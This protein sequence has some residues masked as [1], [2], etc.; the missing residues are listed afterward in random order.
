MTDF[1]TNKPIYQQIAEDI[2]K[3]AVRGEILPGDRIPSARE[4]ASQKLVNPNT[5]VRAFQD[6]EREGLVVVKRGL[7]NYLTTDT[8]RLED[9][10]FQLAQ[11]TLIQCAKDLRELGYTTKQ[12]Q[13]LLS[14]QLEVMK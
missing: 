14:Q 8:T 13:Q 4:Y 2:L 12:I 6:L 5:V 1:D 9:A 7:G 10:R 11:K 3:K